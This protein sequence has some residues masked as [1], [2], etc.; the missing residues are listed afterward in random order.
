[1]VRWVFPWFVKRQLRKFEQNF[2]QQNPNAARANERQKSKDGDVKVSMNEPKK[3]DKDEL[4]DYI[5]FEDI[6]E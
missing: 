1:M 6:D 5:D 2:Y 4:G 3:S